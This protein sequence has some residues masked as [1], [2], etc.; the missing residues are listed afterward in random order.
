MQGVGL[1][2]FVFIEEQSLGACSGGFRRILYAESACSLTSNMTE[3][4]R[5]T[6]PYDRM[7]CISLSL[8]FLISLPGYAAGQDEG[9]SPAFRPLCEQFASPFEKIEPSPA[10]TPESESRSGSLEVSGKTASVKHAAEQDAK[11]SD[12]AVE[13]VAAEDAAGESHKLT[14]AKTEPRGQ[15][16]ELGGGASVPAR[17]GI[18]APVPAQETRPASAGAVPLLSDANKAFA[19]GDCA[20]P[21]APTTPVVAPPSP[22]LSVSADAAPAPAESVSEDPSPSPSASI[23]AS[24]STGS[25]REDEPVIVPSVPCKLLM[26]GD[27]MM[28][29]FALQLNRV[30]REQRGFNIQ[31]LSRRSACLSHSGRF[32]FAEKLDEAIAEHRPDIIVLLLG[33]WDDVAIHT[34]EGYAL[35]G[36]PAWEDVYRQRVSGV[37]EVLQRHGVPTIWVGLPVMG[38]RNAATLRRIAEITQ[39]QAHDGVVSYIDNLA[40]LADEEGNYLASEKVPGRKTVWLRLRDRKHLARAGNERM[41]QHFLPVFVNR[42]RAIEA[43]RRK[44]V[45]ADGGDADGGDADGASKSSDSLPATLIHIRTFR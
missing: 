9:V 40:L 33:C 45:D 26:V 16:P 34:E 17:S 36:T 5:I 3:Y 22:A 35:L 10:C 13:A 29:A 1:G 19:H 27:T 24:P 2:F 42:L 15:N 18:E 28:E 11:E 44:T 6:S 23:V 31:V 32:R 7:R 37:M 41:V 21:S 25:Q 43:L 38:C 39:E 20:A 14:S 8:C 4:F 30:L 12:A